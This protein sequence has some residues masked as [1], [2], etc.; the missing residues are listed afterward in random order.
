M[1][2]HRSGECSQECLSLDS[3]GIRLIAAEAEAGHFFV[4][5][6]PRQVEFLHYVGHPPP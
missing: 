3:L 6:S 1:L 2:G 5:R 4:E